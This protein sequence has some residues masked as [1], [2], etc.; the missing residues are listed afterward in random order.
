MSI[1][2]RKSQTFH[3]GRTSD[4]KLQNVHLTLRW[5]LA[6]SALLTSV[7][8]GGMLK[9]LSSETF[10]INVIWLLT[11]QEMDRISRSSIVPPCSWNNLPEMAK[12]RMLMR[13]FAIGVT[14]LGVIAY[15]G[16]T[17]RN[18]KMVFLGMG[19]S[20]IKMRRSWG[21]LNFITGIP[22]PVRRQVLIEMPLSVPFY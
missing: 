9:A 21:R 8:Y 4:R 3:A 10:S 16:L 1:V 19:I 6:W 5:S 17:S 7:A 14:G 12:N 15:V 22:I 11:M 20:I 18:I 13:C 2:I